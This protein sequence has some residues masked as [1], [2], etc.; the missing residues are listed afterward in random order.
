MPLLNKLDRALGWMAI[1]SLPIYIVTAQSLTYIWMMLNPEQ[2]HLL[3]LDPLAVR[4]SHEY[5][6]VL[7]YL[8]VT[9]IQNPIFAFF[10]LYLLYTYGTAL[11]EEWGSF[12]FTLFYL[13]G[14]IG[15]SI[16]GLIFGN[17]DGAFFLNM[18][19]F[20]AFAAHYPDFQILLFFV[21]PFKI[22]WLAWV[23]WAWLGFQILTSPTPVR[24]AIL[25][26]FLNYLLFFGKAHLESLVAKIRQIRHRQRFKQWNP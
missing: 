10:Y 2:A 14:V 19:L 6:R 1:P 24:A 5:W 13:M 25:I 11:E 12:P 20:L 21:I 3:S 8:F 7:T 18:T 15:T 16:A 9:P 26:S 22:K 17:V 23:T 4:Y